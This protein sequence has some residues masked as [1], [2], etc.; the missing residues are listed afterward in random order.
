[1]SYRWIIDCDHVE[2]KV[3][4]RGPRGINAALDNALNNG[5]GKSFRMYDDDGELYYEGRLVTSS[6]EQ[7]PEVEFRP[8]SDFGMPNAGATEIHYRDESGNW[9]RI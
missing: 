5:E 2:S 1:M 9:Q 3:G 4:V 8:L 7:D 6:D